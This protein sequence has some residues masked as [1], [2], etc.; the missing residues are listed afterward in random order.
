MDQLPFQF[1]RVTFSLPVGEQRKGD[2][3]LLARQ[4]LDRRQLLEAARIYAFSI[5]KHA[6][7]VTIDDVYGAMVRDGLKPTDLGNAAG[8]LFRG[9]DFEFRGEWRKSPRVS[10]HARFNRVWRL[11]GK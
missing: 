1:D 4:P 8:S 5:A 6:G 9:E 2:G 7:S 11:R 10:N 3:M